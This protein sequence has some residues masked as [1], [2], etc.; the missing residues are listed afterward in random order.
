MCIQSAGTRRDQRQLV[1]E[2]RLASEGKAMDEEI[3]EWAR[4]QIIEQNKDTAWCDLILSGDEA[5]ALE[6]LVIELRDAGQNPA[7]ERVFNSILEE[8]EASRSWHPGEPWPRL[9]KPD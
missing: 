6:Q 2:E 1:I 5:K 4:K 7:L 8:I 3:R 9:G